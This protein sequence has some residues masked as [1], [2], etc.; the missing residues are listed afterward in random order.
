MDA[1]LGLAQEPLVW[2][3]CFATLQ[4]GFLWVALLHPFSSALWAFAHPLWSSIDC[5]LRR[6]ST[7]GNQTAEAP[8]PAHQ[9]HF[10]RESLKMKNYFNLYFFF[11]FRS[12]IAF[13]QLGH[14]CRSMLCRHW[15]ELKLV[16]G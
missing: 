14:S 9:Q 10:E 7:Q 2:T 13:H 8:D 11:I 5:G 16:S 6:R 4:W 1:D 3:P 12:S 15:P